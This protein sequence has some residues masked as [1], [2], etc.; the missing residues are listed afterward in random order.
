MS[1]IK[2]IIEGPQSAGR[3]RIGNMLKA[4]LLNAG[5]FFI[6]DD[7]CTFESDRIEFVDR[8][9]VAPPVAQLGIAVD[10]TQV[11]GATKAL[12]DLA[13]AAVR[14]QQAVKALI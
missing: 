7:V 11:K 14:A 6:T 9:P 2:V 8:T 4:D 5:A 13:D 10:T 1:D 12:N 3:F